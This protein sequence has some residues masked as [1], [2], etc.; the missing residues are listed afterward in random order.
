MSRILTKKCFRQ[1]KNQAE[2]LN[3]I[4]NKFKTIFINF[5]GGLM[6]LRRKTFVFKGFTLIMDLKCKQQKGRILK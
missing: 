3:M 4:K 2:P 5:N 6:R 1:C